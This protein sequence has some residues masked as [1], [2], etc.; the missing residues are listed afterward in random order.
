MDSASASI[1]IIPV[2]KYSDY[3]SAH[4][5]FEGVS[6]V[7]KITAG[8]YAKKFP[9]A[10]FVFILQDTLATK[11]AATTDYEALCQSVAEDFRAWLNLPDSGVSLAENSFDII[12]APARGIFVDR[13]SG[14]KLCA[15]NSQESQRAWLTHQLIGV[16]SRFLPAESLS[17]YLDT[18]HGI[19]SL[20][21]A[22]AATLDDLLPLCAYRYG[23]VALKMLNSDP[24]WQTGQ[25]ELEINVVQQR[26]VYPDL[27]FEGYSSNVL[28]KGV[29]FKAPGDNELAQS[30]SRKLRDIVD[31]T[32]DQDLQ[33]LLAAL[34]FG[35][36]LA[37]A[38]LLSEVE[39]KINPVEPIFAELRRQT[40]VT[41]ASDEILIE[42][43]A[44][45]DNGTLS[46]LAR[47]H[48]LLQVIGDGF[49]HYTADQGVTL[50]RLQ[51]AAGKIYFKNQIEMK[52][53]T[54]ELSGNQGIRTL[55]EN[56]P[57]D[58]PIRSG[59]WQRLA[60]LKRPQATEAAPAYDRSLSDRN[61]YAH[62]G[63]ELNVV[64]VRLAG[65]EIWLRYAQDVRHHDAMRGHLRALRTSD[66]N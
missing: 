13:K 3:S 7:A 40:T 22:V 25:P 29:F 53:I 54:N 43:K 64:E 36:P 56:A 33:A 10:H 32:T 6:A 48:F 24:Y 46:D 19:N 12:V 39:D 63:F 51:D 15:T 66:R 9:D 26:M 35:F 52:L 58:S 16:F 21:L 2:G 4:Y 17:V 37:V 23:V 38:W 65:E 47:I 20:P 5:S 59:T 8:L 1:V 61:F 49:R 57:A 28:K 11:H 27:P 55:V 42:A 50:A 45:L 62:A 44:V 60:D 30:L 41:V 14:Q 18:S 31:Y 34:R